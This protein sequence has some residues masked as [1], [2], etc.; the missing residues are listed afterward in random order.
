MIWKFSLFFLFCFGSKSKYFMPTELSRW[1]MTSIIHACIWFWI[2]PVASMWGK[3]HWEA[4]EKPYSYWDFMSCF[5]L[6]SL[7]KCSCN[8]YAH[9][10]HLVIS[11]DLVILDIVD[12]EVCPKGNRD[13]CSCSIGSYRDYWARWLWSSI[14][15]R[16]YLTFRCQQIECGCSPS[17][18][19]FR[20]VPIVR[21]SKNVSWLYF[22]VFTPQLPVLYLKH[23][24]KIV[25]LT[26]LYHLQIW[27][28]HYRP[29]RSW[30]TRVSKR[31]SQDL[32]FFLWM[33]L[34]LSVWA[35][36]SDLLIS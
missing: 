29:I 3:Y 6:L 31:I 30:W 17:C 28:E 27:A 35:T 12:G 5:L 4:K 11:N 2:L 21:G 1:M 7:L 20:G 19:K 25:K 32:V 22:V 24:T 14:F 8:Y 34:I 36:I 15:Q 18:S 9:R 16:R 10:I 13:H 26:D 33:N 23:A